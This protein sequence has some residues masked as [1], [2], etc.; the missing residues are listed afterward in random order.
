MIRTY[1]P[2]SILSLTLLIT[3]FLPSSANGQ[4]LAQTKNSPVLLVVHR[5]TELV[6]TETAGSGHSQNAE[7]LPAETVVVGM[8]QKATDSVGRNGWHVVTIDQTAHQGWIPASS[9]TEFRQRVSELQTTA[10]SLRAQNSAPGQKQTLPELILMQRNPEVQRAWREIAQAVEDNEKLPESD[11]LPEP[12]FARAEIWASVQNYSDSLRDFLTGIRYA[13]QSN[14]DL[15]SYSAYFERM[16]D[17][18]EEF[19]NRPVPARGVEDDPSDA[20]VK[21]YSLGMNRYFAGE[22]RA[23]L[24][25]FNDAVQLSPD[26]AVYW[27]YRAL[28][29]RQLGEEGRAQYDALMG[30]TFEKALPSWKQRA[31]HGE[32]VR[33][34]GS[35]RFWLEEFRLGSQQSRL[36]NTYRI[37]ASPFGAN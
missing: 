16:Y 20:A 7:V 11:R 8:E 36:L 27:Y 22:Y 18:A 13:R 2:L 15:L 24:R 17:V 6:A 25:H 14:R 3:A 4:N 30:A 33:I 10:I 21:H 34:Q 23:A 32:L 37:E 35:I 26:K 5:Q 29:H 19:E 12:Y 31:M 9:V 28:T 1:F